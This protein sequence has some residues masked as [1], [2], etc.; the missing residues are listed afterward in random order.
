MIR[1]TQEIEY[2][3]EVTHQL[4]NRVALV[5]M[6]QEPPVGSRASSQPA[7]RE[8]APVRRAAFDR[9]SKSALGV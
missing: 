6:Q 3:D 2:I 1:Q 7:A 9:G 4:A 5:P 8:Q